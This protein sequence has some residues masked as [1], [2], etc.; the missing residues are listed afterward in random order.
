MRGPTR[1]AN[2]AEVVATPLPHSSAIGVLAETEREL[3]V[4]ASQRAGGNKSEAARILGIGRDAL[5]YKLMKHD[6][7]TITQL[8]RRIDASAASLELS[9]LLSK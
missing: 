1:P 9:E 7:E 4:R 5:R 2:V 3:I 6:L 8:R